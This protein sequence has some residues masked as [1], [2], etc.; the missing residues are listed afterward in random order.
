MPRGLPFFQPRGGQSQEDLSAAA[1][2][3]RSIEVVYLFFVFLMLLYFCRSL[4][5]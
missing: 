1:A 3:P 2:K 5:C 4:L